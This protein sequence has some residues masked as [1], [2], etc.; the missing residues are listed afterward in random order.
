[1]P[2]KFDY[3]QDGPGKAY[4][5]A[6]APIGCR[7]YRTQNNL[8]KLGIKNYFS[9]CVTLTLKKRDIPKPEKEYIVI[10]G[11]E[12]RVRDA[13]IKQVKEATGGAVDVI[14]IKPKRTEKS[15]NIPWEEREKKVLEYLDLYQN[16]KCVVSFMLHCCLPCLALETPVLC[17]RHNF[18]SPRF[19]PYKDW[20][21]TASSQD[22]VD[23]KYIDFILNPPENPKDYLAVR[24]SLEKTITEFISSAEKETRKASDLYRL[25][26]SDEEMRDWKDRHMRQSL[27]TFV[28]EIDLDTA[29]MKKL[30]NDVSK[31]KEQLEKTKENLKKS[32]KETE[33]LKI[34]LK[35]A[36][37][38]GLGGLARK[39]KR[40]LTK[41]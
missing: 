22:V 40:K 33:I 21:H 17:V 35:E 9:G 36:Q 39:I 12:S 30:K 16:A 34:R 26:C 3:I 29:E 13:V 4:L 27:A 14:V 5:E 6:Y 41:K 19:S 2:I 28:E 31:L 1:M 24:N 15:T 25:N 23:G 37:D 8:D 11:V 38:N 18:N 10:N 7:D 20:M 32:K